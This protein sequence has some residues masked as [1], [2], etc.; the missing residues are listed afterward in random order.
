VFVI[1]TAVW[2]LLGHWL[3]HQP[4]LGAPIRRYGHR[5]LAFILLACPEIFFNAIVSTQVG[6]CP[7]RLMLA[8]KKRAGIN[9]HQEVFPSLFGIGC[10]CV[11][12]S[13]T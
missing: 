4:A 3:V 6:S 2:C 11:Y 9:E 13:G 8:P 10:G 1:M 5:T 12:Y 7:Y